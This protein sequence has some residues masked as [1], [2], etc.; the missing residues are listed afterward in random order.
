MMDESDCYDVIHDSLL[1]SDRV[2][3]TVFA[4]AGVDVF[5]TDGSIW[6]VTVSQIDKSALEED[7][8]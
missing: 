2:A 3:G 5:M 6:H 1:W 4:G 8:T 7:G